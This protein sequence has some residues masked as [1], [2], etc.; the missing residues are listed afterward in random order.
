MGLAGCST[1]YFWAGCM[2]QACSSLPASMFK[3][4]S[5]GLLIG[6]QY[7]LAVS[8]QIPE[9]ARPSPADTP[10]IRLSICLGSAEVL[11]W[12]HRREQ[13]LAAALWPAW[14]AFGCT[15]PISQG[16]CHHV[17]GVARAHP[18]GELAMP[19]LSLLV[20]GCLAAAAQTCRCSSCNCSGSCVRC[21]A[22]LLVKIRPRNTMCCR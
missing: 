21:Y 7:T 3:H 17:R 13:H 9:P 8:L 19:P 22:S 16:H 10:D 5:L 18:Q 14:P 6:L 15:G 12:L 11:S 20:S 1:D 2:Y 4:T